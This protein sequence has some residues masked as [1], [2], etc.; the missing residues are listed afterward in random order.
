MIIDKATMMRWHRED[1]YTNVSF[2]DEIEGRE[3]H[4]FTHNNADLDGEFFF[5]DYETEEMLLVNGWMLHVRIE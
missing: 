5:F 4:G 2:E 1:Q 3:R